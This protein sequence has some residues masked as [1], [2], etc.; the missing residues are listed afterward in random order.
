MKKI[1]I[2][3][4]LLAIMCGCLAA[5]ARENVLLPTARSAWESVKE[6]VERGVV[7]A[8]ADG[9]ISQEL[10]TV[11]SVDLNRMDTALVSGNLV[12]LGEVDWVTTLEPFAIRGVQ[13][14]VDD[15]EISGGV[16]VS[17]LQRLMNFR[18]VIKMLQT[19]S[20]RS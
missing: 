6:D 4:A 19:D 9:D 18:E 12:L 13:D 7:D 1:L 16:S 2:A 8:M 10:A 11:L 5:K 3:V 14:R 15:D 20:R 17:F